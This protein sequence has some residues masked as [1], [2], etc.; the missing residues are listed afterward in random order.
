MVAAVGGRE[1]V[2]DGG[3]ERRDAFDVEGVVDPAAA[4][5]LAEEPGGAQGPQVVRDEGGTQPQHLSGVADA[6]LPVAQQGHD[7]RAVRL[8]HGLEGDEVV[9]GQRGGG[10]MGSMRIHGCHSKR[11]LYN[12]RL[13]DGPIP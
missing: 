10:Q 11:H 5:A 6:V 3:A 7:P 4:P 12:L 2:G 13:T 9:L 8:R 1:E